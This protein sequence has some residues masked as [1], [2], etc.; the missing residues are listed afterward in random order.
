M[1]HK[2]FSEPTPKQNKM[3]QE[4]VELHQAGQLDAAETQYKKLLTF[5]PSNT[6]LLAH[7][8]RIA[9]QKGDLK[10]AARIFEKSLKINPDQAT[11]LCDK[12]VVLQEL[13][14][15]DESIINFN[16][17]IALNPTFVNAYYNKGVALQ[18]LK[19]FNEA[20]S[21]FNRAIELDPNDVDAYYNRSISL[22]KLKRFEEALLSINHCIALEP[23]YPDAYCNLGSILIDL[24]RYE[25]ALKNINHAIL[26]NPNY[27]EAYNHRGN[28]LKNLKRLDEAL[29]TYDRAITLKPD[30]A[31]AYSNRGV[32]L[33]DLKR[34][35]E[36]L[37]SYDRA[38]ALKPDINF[39]LGSSLHTKMGLC[40]WDDLSHHLNDLTHKINNNKKVAIPFALLALF[41]HPEMQKKTAEIY[42]KKI[43][44]QLHVLPKIDRYSKHSKIRLGYFSADFHNHATMHLMAELFES[45]NKDKFELIAFSFGPDNQD[46]SRQ[47]AFLCFDQF[48]DVRFKSD[49]EIA[50]LARTMEIDI[51]VD[52]KGY[53]QD[54]RTG[55][56][57]EGSAPIQVNYLGYPGTMAVDY[58]DYLI[59]D[60]TLIPEDKQPYYSEKIVYLPNS[61]QVN[62]S[63]RTVTE[64]ALTRQELG[65]PDTGFIFCCFNNNYKITPTTFAGWM[66]ILTAVDGSV[67]WL[68]ESN[69]SAVKNLRKEA[70][71]LGINEERLIFAEYIPIA[72]H[73]NRI[74]M[75]DL[76]MDTLPYNAHTTT[77][78]ALRMG[79][80]VLTLIGESFASRVA[81]S[82]LNAVNL[83][84][85]ITTTQEQYE[86]LAID[87][88]LHPEKLKALKEK[89]ANNLPTAP[90]YN[91]PLFTQHLESAYLTMYDRY[92]KG[93]APEHIYV[94]P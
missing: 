76:F 63:K 20:L 17:A 18:E 48:V 37:A 50:V 22:S 92:Q 36:A 33:Q 19:S 38:I 8:G 6:M 24:N 10:G 26:L 2:K 13:K 89:L 53:T 81:A 66:R 70:V 51:A 74:Q 9:F 69:S 32:T 44:P 58:I 3:I 54:C 42:V 40:L 23:D 78:D 83:P 34:L 27:A 11:V 28:A 39:I 80:P 47:R 87:L 77:S 49:R 4:A 90:L 64:T 15:Y 65:L 45:H 16:K 14:R 29:V 93:L 62:V 75:A 68:F 84:E 35:D 25:E 91:T 5:L 71:K 12:G 59:A 67:L 61:Y 82:L 1:R 52:L 94:E 88:A 7:I 31:E 46:E 56:F 73:L 72:D 43:Y 30:Y 85:L 60:R 57:A 79:L 55:I 41:D 86:S 21:S